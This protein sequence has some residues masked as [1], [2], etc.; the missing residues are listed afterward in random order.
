MGRYRY[1]AIDPGGRIV[2]DHAVAGDERA[3]MRLLAQRNLSPIFI[4]PVGG[5]RFRG[6]VGLPVRPLPKISP[7]SL[8]E[9]TCSMATLLGSR[10]EVDTAVQLAAEATTDR[11]ARVAFG[12]VTDG[13]RSGSDLSGAL[14]ALG[15]RIPDYYV[16][17]VRAGEAGAGVDK[18]FERLAAALEKSGQTREKL[19]SALIYPLILVALALLSIFFLAMF[20]V[21]RFE[22]IFI[23]AGAELPAI[24]AGIVWISRALVYNW[25]ILMVLIPGVALAARALVRRPDIRKLLHTAALHMPVLGSLIRK[26][27]IARALSL[28]SMLLAN[29]VP[30][31]TALRVA[32]TSVRNLSLRGAFRRVAIRI[33]DGSPVAAAL[34]TEQ[35]FEEPLPH[36]AAVGERT[37]ALAQVFATSSLQM[38]RSAERRIERL[39]GLLTPVLTLLLGGMVALI[40]GSLM[41]VILDLN[42]LAL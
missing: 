22:P 38:E 10:V 25:H 30:A 8:R 15:D 37:G 28:W 3:V 23:Q 17:M 35:V 4:S 14:A 18:V 40:M 6:S 20:V 12:E 13:L 26:T 19:R 24:A 27:Q 21:P 2:A 32:G 36:L 34:A 5:F 39:V 7:A 29:G 42:E 11:R 1:K 41:T 33:E 16:S 31:L 9:F